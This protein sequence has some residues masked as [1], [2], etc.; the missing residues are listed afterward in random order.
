LDL[1]KFLRVLR[2]SLG[3]LILVTLVGAL[4][5]VGVGLLQDSG[6]SSN[7]SPTYFSATETLGYDPGNGG[8][9]NTSTIT[10]IGAFVTGPAVTDEIGKQLTTDGT[11][12][13]RQITTV[14]RPTTSSIDITAF[15][16]S[17]AEARRLA[18]R[19]ATT[20][21]TLYAEQLLAQSEDQANQL[22]KRLDDLKARREAV[23]VQLA[24]P[25]LSAVDRDVLNAQSDALV[26]QYRIAYDRFISLATPDTSA[27]PLFTLAGPT[28][29]VVDAGTYNAALERGRTGQNHLVADTSTN[30]TLFPQS[31]SSGLPS[32]PIGLGVLGALLGLAAGVAIVGLRTRFD[33]KLRTRSDFEEAFGLPVLGG[34]PILARDEQAR[35]MLSVIEKPYSPGA[36]VFRSVRSALLLLGTDDPDR[37]GALIV[38]IASGQP[39]EGKSATCANL[40]V[41]FA[42]SG[43]SVLAVNCDYR[44]PTLHH[45]FELANEPGRIL[46]TEITGLSV[47]TNV[48]SSK[49]SPGRVA[50]E[51][52]AFIEA[53]RANYDVILLDTGPLLGTSDPVDIAP[54]VDFVLLVGRPN[55]SERD[56]AAQTMELL[57]RHRVEVAGLLMTAVDPV[58]SE[59]YYYYSAYSSHAAFD[60]QAMKEASSTVATSVDDPAPATPNAATPVPK[61]HRRLRR[62]TPEGNADGR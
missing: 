57:H 37:E 18:T 43:R 52:R 19:F 23:A 39:K 26:N 12:L 30:S 25:N 6:S 24:N 47:V 2:Q 41:A 32:G 48:Q 14:A 60:T 40:A 22:G 7:N 27:P 49:T 50:V 38:M 1:Q 42:E 61:R 21:K 54:V 51:Q 53:Q 59:Y 33:S 9:A 35:H 28:P 4:I 31:S 62:R 20:T 45:Y 36:E 3:L 17:A 34:V 44:R 11:A 56:H 8:A 13:A 5:G 10:A 15:A 16:E 58:G 29:I 55:L 46:P